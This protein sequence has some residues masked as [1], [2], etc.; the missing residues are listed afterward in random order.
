MASS[1]AGEKN[2]DNLISSPI[3]YTSLKGS[4]ET[5]A[6]S[7]TTVT[8]SRMMA[9]ALIGFGL[10]A[11]IGIISWKI[12]RPVVLLAN[13]VLAV[14]AVCFS[15]VLN[16]MLLAVFM[17]VFQV[18]LKKYQERLGLQVNSVSVNMLGMTMSV[19]PLLPQNPPSAPS[20][21]NP[22]STT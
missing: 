2:P 1:I 7:G 14:G 20:A 18:L 10:L 9:I 4:S 21:Q 13:P 5:I 6:T 12:A 16:T 15:D 3:P 17:V 11:T 22:P 19:G 8:H